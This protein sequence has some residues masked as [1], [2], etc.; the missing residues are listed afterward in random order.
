MNYDVDNNICVTISV[1]SLVFTFYASKSSELEKVL[2][3]EKEPPFLETAKR[4]FSTK[5]FTRALLAFI[6]SISITNVVGKLFPTSFFL[7]TQK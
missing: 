4:L 2:K 5:G 3:N 7:E 6:C 1:F